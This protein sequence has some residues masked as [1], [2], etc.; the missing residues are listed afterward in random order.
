MN[1]AAPLR[2]ATAATM[3]PSKAL[4]IVDIPMA[5]ATLL[6]P[7]PGLLELE[8]ELE[9]LELTLGVP[10]AVST[11]P[12]SATYVEPSALIFRGQKNEGLTLGERRQGEAGFGVRLRLVQPNADGYNVLQ[13]KPNYFIGTYGAH[14]KTTNLEGGL[15]LRI[16]LNCLLHREVIYLMRQYDGPLL[17]KLSVTYSSVH[18]VADAQS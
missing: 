3:V 5:P 18:S 11:P 13:N 17:N 8:L 12:M 6:P 9:V 14:K 4:L 15:Q 10:D 2:N 7:V 16:E 1:C